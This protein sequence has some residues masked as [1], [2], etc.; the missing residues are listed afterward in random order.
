MIVKLQENTND[1][2][3]WRAVILSDVFCDK[4]KGGDGTNEKSINS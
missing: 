1:F 4:S 3:S 2:Y